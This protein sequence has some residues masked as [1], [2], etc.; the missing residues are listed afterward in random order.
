VEVRRDGR[1]L[2][3]VLGTL[4]VDSVSG[5][6]SFGRGDE[7]E[8]RVLAVFGGSAEDHGVRGDTLGRRKTI[9]MMR[10][11][12]S[13]VHSLTNLLGLM[14]RHPEDDEER[15]EGT[16]PH[17]DG[18]HVSLKK[19]K[20]RKRGEIESDGVSRLLREATGEKEERETHD[21]D[22]SGTL[23]LLEGH[24]LDETRDDGTGRLLSDVD[25]LD[26]ER[27]GIWVL[28]D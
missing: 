4:K 1:G 27:V 16:N 10:R 17:L 5:L 14:A 24:V 23:H 15:E 2:T 19:E 3:L 12:V 25:L 18:L 21:D 7:L 9:K 28:L 6:G 13:S 22:D 20:V 11:R 26:V 8:T